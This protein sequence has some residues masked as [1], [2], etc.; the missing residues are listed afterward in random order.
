MRVG[1]PQ[2]YQLPGSGQWAHRHWSQGRQAPPEAACYLPALRGRVP[3]GGKPRLPRYHASLLTSVQA[4]A[5][6][7]IH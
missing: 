1:A 4:L 2:G 7:V 5:G 6:Q 3:S